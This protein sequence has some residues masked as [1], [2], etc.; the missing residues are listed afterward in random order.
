MDD[1][2]RQATRLWTLAQPVVSAFVV[3][4]V[5]D[6]AARDDVLQETAVAVVESFDRYDPA[7]PF[8]AWA[9]GIAQNQVRLYFRR[10][11]RERLVFDDE[12]LKHLAHA[13][14]TTP[15]AE[16]NALGFLQDCLSQVEGRA[17]RMCELRYTHDLK[18]AAIAE[19]LGMTANGVSKALQRIRDQLRQCIQQKAAAEGGAG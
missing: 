5:R 12:A 9:L 8:V 4:A 1:A 19:S 3:A 13:F 2:T 7:R 6:F 10:Q 17:R 14:D 18:P 16:L 11:Q 15:Q